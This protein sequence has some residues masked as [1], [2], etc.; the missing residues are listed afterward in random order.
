MFVCT[1]SLLLVC[2]LKHKPNLYFKELASKH[3]LL[4]RFRNYSQI[5][6]GSS[7]KKKKI[8]NSLSVF[9]KFRAAA[10]QFCRRV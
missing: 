5:F 7:T 8:P 2:L 1:L 3:E 9:I 10:S 4:M 6:G